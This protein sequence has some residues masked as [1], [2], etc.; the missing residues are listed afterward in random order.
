MK[1][2]AQCERLGVQRIKAQEGVRTGLCA[3]VVA[4]ECLRSSVEDFGTDYE[5]DIEEGKRGEEFRVAAV[6]SRT[7]NFRIGD[8]PGFSLSGWR[9]VYLGK[10]G[11]PDTECVQD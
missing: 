3:P 2:D 10:E 6:P 11:A 1:Y 4:L 8:I 5:I 7:R 9:T